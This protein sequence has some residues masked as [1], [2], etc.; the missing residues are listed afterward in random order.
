MYFIVVPIDVANQCNIDITTNLKSVDGTKVLF[1]FNKLDSTANIPDIIQTIIANATIMTS[2]EI[3]A[4]PNWT[5][6]EE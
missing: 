5:K 6:P 4:D 3:E 2:E 1:H